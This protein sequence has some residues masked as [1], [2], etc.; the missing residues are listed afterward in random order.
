M[1]EEEGEEW[2]RREEEEGWG[3]MEERDDEWGERRWLRGVAT[4]L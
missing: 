2:R 1:Q 3:R 4:T